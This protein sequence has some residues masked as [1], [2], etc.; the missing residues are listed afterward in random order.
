VTYLIPAFGVFWGRLFLEEPV[1]FDM[2][3]GCGVILLGTALANG[4]IGPRN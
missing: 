1:T 2:L 3:A 4:L